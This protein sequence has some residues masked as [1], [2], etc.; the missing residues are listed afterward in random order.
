MTA[1]VIWDGHGAHTAKLLADLPTARI[2]LPAYSP[3]LNPAERTFAEIRRRTEVGA[4]PTVHDKQ[5]VVDAFLHD[6]AAHPARVRRLC[7]WAWL[8]AALDALP[9]A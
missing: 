4:Y 5:A 9:A 3:D 7:G 8:T 6:L 2:H 1:A